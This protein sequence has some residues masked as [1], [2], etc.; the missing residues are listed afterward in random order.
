MPLNFDTMVP[1][2]GPG[3]SRGSRAN[4]PN[5]FLEK[6]WLWQ[7]YEE[8]KDKVFGPI[9][10]AQEEYTVQKGASAGQTKT[11]WTGDVATVISFL[12]SAA[13]H[14]NI[15]VQV[16][17]VQ[18]LNERE[19]PIKGMYV[20]QYLGRERQIRPRRKTDDENDYEND[21]E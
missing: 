18:A 3:M 12:R 11:R 6:G 21:D 4:G 10:G 15:G 14:Q 17:V 20:V 5:P 7:S 19:R 16:E 2:D 13:D 8:G 9:T 1:S